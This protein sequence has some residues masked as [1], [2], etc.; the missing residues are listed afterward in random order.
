MKRSIETAD[1]N[2]S[3][4]VKSGRISGPGGES[5]DAFDVPDGHAP[6]VRIGG[7]PALLKGGSGDQERVLDQGLVFAPDGSRLGGMPTAN[8]DL[9]AGRLFEDPMIAARVHVVRRGEMRRKPGSHSSR[10][11][12]PTSTRCDASSVKPAC[13]PASSVSWSDADKETHDGL[14]VGDP[15]DLS[16][17]RT[18]P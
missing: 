7:N 11:A 16:M 12:S 8:T 5:L 2:H 4:P 9:I 17:T 10:A 18:I 1:R 3:G 15:S 13:R 6:T 14:L